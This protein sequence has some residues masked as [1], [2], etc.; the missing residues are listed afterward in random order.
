M[1]RKN[2]D[3]YY[4]HLTSFEDLRLER[5]RLILKGRIIETRININIEE[6]RSTF[7]FSG[8]VFSMIKKFFFSKISDILSIFT[9]MPENEDES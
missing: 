9:R 6:I 7:S 5:T 2:N 4:S 1:M 8:L 3:S